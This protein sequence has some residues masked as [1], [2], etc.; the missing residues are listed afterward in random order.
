MTYGEAAQ[1]A[2]QKADE[3]GRDH[4]IS[5]DALGQFHVR[6]LPAKQYRFGADLQ[7]EIRYC[8]SLDRTQPGHGCA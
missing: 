4:G 3:T 7:C 1:E 8:T 5:K 2:Q 6:T